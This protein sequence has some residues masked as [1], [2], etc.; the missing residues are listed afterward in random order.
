MID[1]RQ[2][3]LASLYALDLLEGRER[4]QFEAAL[5]RERELQ[6]L[7]RELRNAASSLAHTAPVG[8]VP[9]ALKQRVIA[10]ITATAGA[11]NSERSQRNILFVQFVPWAIAASFAVIAALMTQRYVAQQSEASAL[12][13]HQALAEVA[14]KSLTQQ[15]EAE[16]I[17][18]STQIKTLADQAKS[19]GNDANQRVAAISSLREQLEAERTLHSNQIRTLTEQMRMQGDLANLKIAALTSLLDSAPNAAAIAVWDPQRQEGVFALEKLPPVAADQT[20][21]LWVVE[22]KEGARP[23]SAGVLTAATD[24]SARGRFKPTIPVTAIKA[25]A[26]SREVKD[27]AAAHAAPSEVIMMGA[28]R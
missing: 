25:F 28:S 2:E 19:Q 5:A 9:A 21:E 11:R 4:V 12:R 6:A 23:I 18:N 20:L 10:S 13:Q 3:E 15:L 24:G 17:L 8:T 26:I 1:E 14:V 27:G 7:V 22:N 16:R